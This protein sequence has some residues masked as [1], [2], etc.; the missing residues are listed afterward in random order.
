MEI[1]TLK[2]GS[3]AQ[4]S[5]RRHCTGTIGLRLQLDWVGRAFRDDQLL[6]ADD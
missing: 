6:R 3:L 4:L 2:Q 1:L 5:L